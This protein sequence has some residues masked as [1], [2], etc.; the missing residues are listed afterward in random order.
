MEEQISV[1]NLELRV[2]RVSIPQE[3][4]QSSYHVKARNK[5]KS[6]RKVVAVAAARKKNEMNFRN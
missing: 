3:T 6:K 1:V 4:S 2:S 5:L